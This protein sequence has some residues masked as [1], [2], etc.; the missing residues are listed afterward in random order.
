MNHSPDISSPTPKIFV[1]GGDGPYKNT[2]LLLQKIDLSFA[3]GKQVLL[4]PNIGR[5]AEPDTGIVTNYMVVAA[6]IDAFRKAGA[7][8]AV[9][10]S[11]IVGVDIKEAFEKSDEYF[12]LTEQNIEQH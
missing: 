10:E 5:A 8:V 2:T 12:L 7:K 6:A 1:A 9:G 3:R 11:P 4:K